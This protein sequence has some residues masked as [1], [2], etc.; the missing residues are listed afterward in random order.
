MLRRGD[1]YKGCY[2]INRGRA[3]IE[4]TVSILF[5]SNSCFNV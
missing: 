1:S 3:V 2:I 4:T 5:T